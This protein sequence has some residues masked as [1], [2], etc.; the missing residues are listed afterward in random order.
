LLAT[1]R[2]RRCLTGL[3]LVIKADVDMLCVF[4]RAPPHLS[5]NSFARFSA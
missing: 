1:V 3:H 4:L 2:I 5:D